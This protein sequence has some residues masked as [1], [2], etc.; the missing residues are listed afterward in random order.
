MRQSVRDAILTWLSQFESPPILSPYLDRLGLPTIGVGVLLSTPIPRWPLP[1]WRALLAMPHGMGWPYY[2]HRTPL[3][4]TPAELEELTLGKLG[5]ADAALA[6]LIPSWPL[7][8]GVAQLAR[9]RTAWADGPA[10]PWPHLD[11][12]L[13]ARD[14]AEA[15]RQCLPSDLAAQPPQYRASY[16]AVVALYGLC[17]AWP[18]DELPDPLPSGEDGGGP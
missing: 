13:E 6:R 15:A 2:A 12:A 18:G 4:A 11:A 3:R 10:S 14:W 17:D 16:R 8:P 9:L 1:P 7:L 5:L